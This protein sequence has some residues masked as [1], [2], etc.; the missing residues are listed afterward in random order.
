MNNRQGKI[1]NEFKCLNCEFN[2]RK[3]QF[4]WQPMMLKNKE[5]LQKNRATIMSLSSAKTNP[6]NV[7][8]R[9]LSL[10]S[11][12]GPNKLNAIVKENMLAKNIDK[13]PRTVESAKKVAFEGSRNF[14]EFDMSFKFDV[15][16]IMK[17]KA[18]EH[19]QQTAENEKTPKLTLYLL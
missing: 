13:V 14:E 18:E 19:K 4:N 5:I 3:F 12:R 8:E 16:A 15:D 2:K 1:Y 17:Q 6:A 11:H 10:N 7:I 9:S